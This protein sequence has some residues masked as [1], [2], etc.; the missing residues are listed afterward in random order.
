MQQRPEQSGFMPGKSTVDQIL[1]LHVLI[2]RKRE[3]RD[4]LFAAY[5]DLR[6]AFDSVHQDAL[7]RVTQLH[8]LLYAGRSHRCTLL[9]N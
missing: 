5:V 7:W 1:A 6:K 8:G 3:F 4:K 2:E 9:G